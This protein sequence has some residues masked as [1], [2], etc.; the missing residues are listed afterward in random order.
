MVSYL[1]CYNDEVRRRP[2]NNNVRR[3][4]HLHGMFA[5]WNQTDTALGDISIETGHDEL[6]V[7][8]YKEFYQ[9]RPFYEKYWRKTVD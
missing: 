7:P 6:I 8:W 2:G 1:I 9:E 5:N 4:G 3:P